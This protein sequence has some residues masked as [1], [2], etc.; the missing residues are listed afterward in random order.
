MPI[1]PKQILEEIASDPDTPAAARVQA[2]NSLLS[3]ERAGNQR[4]LRL[5]IDITGNKN[6]DHQIQGTSNMCKIS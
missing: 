1:D 5:E 4:T 3:L 6:G 2:V